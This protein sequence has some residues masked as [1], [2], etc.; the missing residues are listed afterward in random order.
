MVNQNLRALNG[1]A[2]FQSQYLQS[3]P[4]LELGCIGI[5]K[6]IIQNIT[7]VQKQMAD[8]NNKTVQYGIF[9]L[10]TYI[11]YRAIYKTLNEL[12]NN[13]NAL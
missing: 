5:V 7:S 2:T 3:I 9:F 12:T 8:N 13:T 11:L 1:L 4:N 10:I 6:N